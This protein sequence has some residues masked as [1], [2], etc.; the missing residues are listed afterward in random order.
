MRELMT[1][2]PRLSGFGPYAM[3]SLSY[4][5]NACLILPS[6]RRQQRRGGADDTATRFG[7]FLALSDSLITS[8]PGHLYVDRMF[9]FQH[10]AHVST[11]RD[12][13]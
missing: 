3:P 1:Q 11:T 13:L 6:F 9:T 5:L 4:D 10:I 12:G 8:R 2:L 7:G